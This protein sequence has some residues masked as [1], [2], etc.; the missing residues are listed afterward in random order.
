ME[1]VLSKFVG[2]VD[3]LEKIHA[4]I[5]RHTTGCSI[6]NIYG[7]GGVGKTTLLRKI[8]EEYS[9]LP[10]Y[11]VTDIID[12]SQT[13]S[14]VQA[15][16]EAKITE[17]SPQHFS[18]YIAE[19]AKVDSADSVDRPALLR[20]VTE[21]FI[22]EYNKFVNTGIKF[23]LLIDTIELV[24]ETSLFEGLLDV[25]S[26]L[27]NIV[28]VVAGRCI[29]DVIDTE[30]RERITQIASERPLGILLA[31]FNENEAHSYFEQ[32]AKDIK[33]HPDLEKSIYQ[34]SQGNPIKIALSLDWL[35]RGIPLMD[36]ITQLDPAKLQ[37]LPQNELEDLQKQFERALMSGIRGLENEQDSRLPMIIQYM[38]HLHKRFNRGMVEFFFLQKITDKK[39]KK[40]ESD[41]LLKIIETLPFV[42]YLNDEY[43]VLH[44]EMTRLVQKYVWDE[45][46]DPDKELRRSISTKVLEYYNEEILY[47][48]SLPNPTERQRITYWSYLAETMYYQ[49]YADFKTGYIQ[50][51]NLFEN[52]VDN[53]RPNLASLAVEFLKEY[54]GQPEYSK[55][56]KCFVDGYYQG[57]IYLAQGKMD[58]AEKILTN[59]KQTFED[60]LNNSGARRISPLD[61]HLLGRQYDIDNQLGYLYRNLG[62]HPLAVIHYNRSLDYALDTVKKLD[63][64]P[65]N[66]SGRKKELLAKIAETLNNLANV[67][68]LLGE[69]HKA[70]IECLTSA[71]LR[72]TWDEGQLA[73]SR[74]VMAMIMWEMGGTAEAIHYLRDAEQAC[75]QEDETTRALISKYRAYLL[76]RAGST[77]EELWPRLEQVEGIFSRRGHYSELAD[78]LNLKCR[79]NRDKVE[80]LDNP[81]DKI[82]YLQAAESYALDALNKA[83]ESADR[84]R[85]SECHLTLARLYLTWSQ[86]NKG[87]VNTTMVQQAIDQHDKGLKLAEDGQYVRLLSFFKG[88][89]GD[90]EFDRQA[91]SEALTQYIQQCE[92]AIRFKRSVLDRAID[93]LGD[94]LRVLAKE[95][96]ATNVKRY[97][98]KLTE[99]W[100]DRELKGKCQE[101]LDEIEQVMGEVEQQ[102]CLDQIS[103]QYEAAFNGGHWD[104]AIDC[105]NEMLALPILSSGVQRAK[106]LLKKAQTLHIQGDLT[107]A[108]RLAKAVLQIG[109][110]LKDRDVTGNAYLLLAG[111]VWDATN[112]AEAAVALKRAMKEFDEIN[113]DLGKARAI[114]LMSFIQM[115]TDQFDGP[116]EE[117]MKLLP[118]FKKYKLDAELADVWN[119]LSRIARTD[120]ERLKGEAHGRA[121]SESREYADKALKY[122]ESSGDSYKI[123]E[124][125]L[126]MAFIKLEEKNY[127]EALEFCQKGENAASPKTYILQSVCQELR[128]T[129]IFKQIENTPNVDLSK[130]EEIIDAYTQSLAAAARSKPSRLIYLA[131]VVYHQLMRAPLGL[132]PA[133][134]DRI[135]AKWNAEPSTQKY[136]IVLE[137]CDQAIRYRPFVEQV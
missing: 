101:L 87:L 6:I 90:I 26:K 111:V 112:T 31:G 97:A 94:R 7:S 110:N 69:F 5:S 133:L 105:C 21:I 84:F 98:A 108:R 39:R 43:F 109:T 9:N 131:D 134:T 41:A 132:L 81:V 91:Y 82:K 45:V 72:K 129:A 130:W 117:L 93:T 47:L 28:I 56:V 125:Y 64:L 24:Q 135:K 37:T 85:L 120:P 11:A 2:R 15:W 60:I 53:F 42:K 104:K 27:K 46:A 49:L 76:Y 8:K 65:S 96:E 38:A 35:K 59:G 92:L 55:L 124:A 23:I 121:M 29:S 73:K 80:I 52:L 122:A 1:E 16:V 119:L 20:H 123:A 116:F 4:Q 126:T 114:R 89:K 74:Y 100:I 3:E 102:E 68:R 95:Q 30:F 54:S 83:T 10:G 103:D 40:E 18:L 17:A 75:P 48:H 22:D 58:D 113:D 67:H 13:A 106:I 71:L 77:E 137:M 136:P 66:S 70:Q 118:V 57:G 32:T 12:F 88:I 14:R 128:G 36:G 99:Y 44:D 61:E 107:S 25:F 115:R 127:R 19:A 62:K 34:L 78:T 33:I 79:I 50:F 63:A 86:I 51:E